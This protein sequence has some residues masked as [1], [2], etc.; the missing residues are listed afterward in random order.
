MQHRTG[1][2]P[3]HPFPPERLAVGAHHDEIGS[4]AAGDLVQR[5]GRQS[6]GDLQGHLQPLSLQLLLLRLQFRPGSGLEDTFHPRH[7]LDAD[8]MVKITCLHPRAL[9]SPAQATISFQ[10]GRQVGGQ[11]NGLKHGHSP[12][13]SGRTRDRR[14]SPGPGAAPSGAWRQSPRRRKPHSIRE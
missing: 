1:E 3:Q 5:I 13:V 9:N 10:A 11:D 12:W 6:H 4:I 2:A 7:E 14:R 8:H